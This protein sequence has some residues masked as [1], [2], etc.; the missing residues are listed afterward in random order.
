M[1]EPARHDDAWGNPSRLDEETRRV[2]E[3][4]SDAPPLIRVHPDRELPERSTPGELGQW[5]FRSTAPAG[6]PADR[7]GYALGAAV[8]RSRQMRIH[9]Q[10]QVHD[11]IDDLRS[12]FQVIRGRTTQ[13]AQETASHLQRDAR[14]NLREMR[15]RAEHLAHD[16]PI[17]FVLGAAG[18]AFAIGFLLGWWRQSE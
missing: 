12:R 2:G 11:R 18:T 1:S 10:D 9:L 8:G 3:R 17:H 13:N 6:N 14:R 4:A 16:Y 5:P 7:A 15:S